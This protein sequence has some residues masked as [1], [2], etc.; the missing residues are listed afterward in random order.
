[1]DPRDGPYHAPVQSSQ[2]TSSRSDVRNSLIVGAS[3][4]AWSVGA[5]AFYLVAGRALGPTDYG[6]VAALISVIV[7][8]AMPFIALQWSIARVVAA[9]GAANRVGA[10]AAYRRGTLISTAVVGALAA[11][12]TA[13]TVVID[14]VAGP[15]PVIPL[16]ITYVALVVMVP[17]LMA[18]GALQGESRYPG[19]AWSYASSGVLRAP[20]LLPLL[21]LPI[22]AVNSAMAA[23]AL[24]V[25]IGAAWALMLTQSDL[26][27]TAAPPRDIW[28]DFLSAL[29]PVAVGLTG[30][31]VLTNV[32]VVAAKI[33]LGGEEA[34][35]FG[36]ASVV[37]K[38]LLVV[39]QALTLVLLPR[40]AA[41]QA[42][43]E[44]TG[45]LLAGGVLVM[46]VAGIAAMVVAVPL[47][48]PIMNLAFGTAFEPAAAL[49][50]PFLGATTLLGAL[51]ILVNHH[52]A[53][54]D[55]RFVW[56]VGGLAIIQIALLSFFSTSAEAIIVIDAAV[57]GV[58]LVL[59]EVMYFSTDE[60]MLKGAGAQIASTFRRARRAR[61]AP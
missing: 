11:I 50:V 9:A 18:C 59:H 40:V 31:A 21:A 52:V 34:G 16:V 26:R 1:V 39:P 49:L 32:D 6:L 42:R 58:G 10:L 48:S 46:A 54:S 57:A 13:I 27:L 37:A 17:L 19:L 51:L 56:A 24:A 53:R 20:L 7:V 28:N 61:G 29:P 60:S 4:A 38:S 3:I 30:I 55:H 14:A 33:S 43:G 22:G 36:A 35:L 23:V 2:A 45:S 12:A 8:V 47:E 15:I 44:R 25:A 5:F 41:R